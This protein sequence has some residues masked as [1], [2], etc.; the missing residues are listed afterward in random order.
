M[1]E[2]FGNILSVLIDITLLGVTGALF[3]ILGFGNI[4]LATKNGF[5][6]N[7]ES[8][9]YPYIEEETV[10]TEMLVLVNST[11]VIVVA[12]VVE[13]F[14]TKNIKCSQFF[15]CPLRV[16]YVVLMASWYV[17]VNMIIID[18]AKAQVG[19]LRPHFLNRCNPNVTCTEKDF[20]YHTDY[21]CQDVTATEE[22]EARLSFPSGHASY[23][24]TVMGFVIVYIQKRFNPSLKITLLKPA[25]HFSI[26]TL[27]VWIAMTRVADYYHRIDDVLTGFKLGTLIGL[28]GGYHTVTRMENVFGNKNEKD[29][30]NVEKG[31]NEVKHTDELNHESQPLLH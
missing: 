3:Y 16:L 6:C 14:A 20:T 4:L 31:E 13:L 2:T 8:I 21:V 5:F 27:A 1:N 17:Q 26:V 11:V 12:L 18:V 22:N 29:M 19:R 25:I 23:S 10:T 15:K 7:D 28:L 30:E 24:A 9:R